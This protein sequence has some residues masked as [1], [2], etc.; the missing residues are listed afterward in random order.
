[1]L[2][3]L[4][5]LTTATYNINREKIQHRVISIVSVFQYHLRLEKKIVPKH[6]GCVR[7]STNV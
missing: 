3:L 1:M 7:F 4:I 5:G 2:L 6:C